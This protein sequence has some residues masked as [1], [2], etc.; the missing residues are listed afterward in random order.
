[1]QTV[2]MTP[3]LISLQVSPHPKLGASVTITRSSSPLFPFQDDPS[4]REAPVEQLDL[5]VAL[6]QNS[7]FSLWQNIWLSP[8]TDS[9]VGQGI[10]LELRM[11]GFS[12][13]KTLTNTTRCFWQHIWALAYLPFWSVDILPLRLTT[14]L[15]SSSFMGLRIDLNCLKK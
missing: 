1:M 9:R 11:K 12:P 3:V 10:L 2:L 4:A 15:W 14:G 5:E 6:I 13:D 8:R 7:G